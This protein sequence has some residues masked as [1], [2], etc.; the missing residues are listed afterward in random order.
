MHQLKRRE[1][2]QRLGLLGV[3]TALPGWLL[4]PEETVMKRQIP[5]SNEKIPCVG[6]GTW[7]TFDVGEGKTEREPLR[8]VLSTLVEKGAAVV[9][10]SPMYGESEQVVGDLST[11]LGV[12]SKLFIATKI[13]TTGL[14]EGITQMDNS[15]RQLRRKQIDLMQVHNLVD[16][17][18]HLKTLQDWKEKGKIRYIGLTHY[19]DSAHP[20]VENIIRNNPIDFIQINYSMRS[21]HAGESLLPAAIEKNV[22][23]LINRPFEEGSLF[24]LVRGKSLPA[25]ASEFDCT[26]WAQ[27]FLKFILSNPAVTCVIPGTSKAHHL[28]D[29]LKAGTGRLP[30]E[31]Q[32]KQMLSYVS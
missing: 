23:V 3:A 7:Q 10:S 15:F 19:L 31:K 26:S 4:K 30:D 8:A 1:L 32:R 22:A 27:F 17:K 24:N 13:W 21:T 18:T 20:T 6:L 25:L 5:S 2:I 12:N 14:R 28:A 16:W 11:E 29:N 9:D